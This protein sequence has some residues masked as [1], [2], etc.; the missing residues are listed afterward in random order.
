MDLLSATRRLKIRRGGPFDSTEVNP[1]RRRTPGWDLVSLG[2]L[3]AK[4][5]G[6]RRVA[7]C[8][9]NPGSRLTTPVRAKEQAYKLKNSKPKA[10]GRSQTPSLKVVPSGGEQGALS[11]WNR[12]TKTSIRA[13]HA[14]EYVH[15]MHENARILCRCCVASLVSF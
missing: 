14:Q 1:T 9:S 7:V 11:W 10:C 12:D 15:F 4:E 5:F 2:P 13:S 6:V 3:L 8:I